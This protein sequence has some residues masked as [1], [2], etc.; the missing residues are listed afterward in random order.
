MILLRRSLPP[1]G[2]DAPQWLLDELM[3][4]VAQS[5]LV[6]LSVEVLQTEHH[7]VDT[8]RGD[9]DRVHIMVDCLSPRVNEVDKTRFT[10]D[11]PLLVLQEVLQLLKADS[12]TQV[13]QNLL[14]SRK[15]LSSSTHSGWR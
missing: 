14:N 10:K 6:L 8:L 13:V 2:V 15:I 12:I 4:E 5:L 7:Q 1:K 9:E 3:S 11:L